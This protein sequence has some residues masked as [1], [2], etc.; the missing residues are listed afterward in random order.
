ML[1]GDLYIFHVH[2]KHKK[3]SSIQNGNQENSDIHETRFKFAILNSV[4]WFT[5]ASL[6][7]IV[8]Y[9]YKPNSSHALDFIAGY[10]VELSLSVD[11]LFV[12][13]M[14]FQYL[15]IPSMYQSRVLF[16]GI[17][18]AIFMRLFIITF[19]IYLVNDFEWLFYV[20]GVFLIYTAYKMLI[21]GYNE[22][23]SKIKEKHKIKTEAAIVKWVKK[24]LRVDDNITGEKFF[25]IKNK[26]LYAT[27]LLIALVLI[28]KSDIVFAMDSIPAIMG[29]TREPFIV[30]SSNIFAIIGLR[31]MY[32]L[33]AKLLSYLK[34]LQFGLCLILGFVGIKMILGG[35]YF[36]IH[37]DTLYSLMFILIV[38]LFTVFFSILSL[39]HDKNR[40][41]GI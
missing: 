38:L 3:A 26:K 8:L 25:T 33:I 16:I 1:L 2:K 10:I 36:N 31:S 15:K 39:K 11:N 29:I 23:F 14:I 13:I 6:F 34:Y 4:F 9:L 28:E 21:A 30:F 17:L 24:Y 27:P 19:G 37:I 40:Q 32:I 22:N 5:C 20:F 12:F 7:A 35:S 18:S 41:N